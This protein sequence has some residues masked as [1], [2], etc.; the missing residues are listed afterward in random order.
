[1][2]GPGLKLNNSLTSLLSLEVPISSL[3]SQRSCISVL[4]YRV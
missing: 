1:M 4:G 2:A 3:E